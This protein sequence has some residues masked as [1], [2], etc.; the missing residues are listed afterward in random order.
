[1]C[2][3][4]VSLIVA[5]NEITWSVNLQQVM[6]ISQ[7]KD[8]MSLRIVTCKYLYPVLPELNIKRI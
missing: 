5:E 8:E 1:M 6:N 3:L 7:I 4:I 2:I